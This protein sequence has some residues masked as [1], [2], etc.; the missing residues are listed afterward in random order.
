MHTIDSRNGNPYGVWMAM[1]SPPFPTPRQT[2]QLLHASAMKPAPIAVAA[3]AV[4]MNLEPNA[5]KVLVV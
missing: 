2:A 3:G 4:M 5:L 1:G